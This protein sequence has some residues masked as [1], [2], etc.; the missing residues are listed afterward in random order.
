MDH[1]L[2]APAAAYGCNPLEWWKNN[3][4]NYPYLAIL[5][6]VYLAV[7]ATSVSS[8]ST[9]SEAGFVIDK[10]RS[11]LLPKTAA[12]LIFLH[13]NRAYLTRFKGTF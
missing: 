1:Y 8:E 7:M 2:S 11:R 10:R 13:R 5:A 3:A 12:K 4:A 9:F 6:R